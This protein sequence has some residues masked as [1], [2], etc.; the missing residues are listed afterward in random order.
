MCQKVEF[1]HDECDHEDTTGRH[2][3]L[4]INN[5]CPY[6]ESFSYNCVNFSQ[7]TKRLDGEVKE[8][9]RV[10]QRQEQV[11]L[12]DQMECGSSSSSCTEA[13]E[14]AEALDTLTQEIAF[15]RKIQREYERGERVR[16]E[17]VDYLASMS[18]SPHMQQ[19][20]EAED[21]DFSQHYLAIARIWATGDERRERMR[22]ADEEADRRTRE[23]IQRILRLQSERK[24]MI[25]RAERDAHDRDWAEIERIRRERLR[26]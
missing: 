26:R 20:M 14:D 18:R 6:E 11:D 16:Q 23:G 5:N 15:Q 4:F 12:E 13:G 10:R 7:T 24:E 21:E 1:V 19:R 9:M 17:Q 22:R 8:E 3:T 25:Y 2:P